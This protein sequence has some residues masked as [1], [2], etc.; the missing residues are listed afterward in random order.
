M[1]RSNLA[2]LFILIASVSIGGCSKAPEEAPASATAPQEVVDLAEDL[3]Q[4][5]AD[6]NAATDQL[7][8]VFIVGPT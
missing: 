8:L 3:A 2:L 6:F 1:T 7:R 4:L 5:K